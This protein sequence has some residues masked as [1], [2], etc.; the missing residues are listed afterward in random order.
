MVITRYKVDG[1][2]LKIALVAD[3]HGLPTK[4]LYKA[5]EGEK[6]DVILAP[7]NIIL[8][9][10]NDVNLSYIYTINETYTDRI[11][12]ADIVFVFMDKNSVPN[13]V[14]DNCD[15]VYGIGTKNCGS[16]NGNIY[17]HRFFADYYLQSIDLDEGYRALNDS[18][19]ESWGE[20]YVDMIAPV[21]N[22]DGKIMVITDDKMFISQ[23]CRHLT[24]GGAEY[25]A[26][27][28]DLDKYLNK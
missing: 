1:P 5:L 28:L 7:G 14:L 15:C 9:S 20:N 3:I 8:E 6:P 17:S 22:T 18:W 10:E 21:T 16:N 23:D 26:K 24:Q 11:R 12:Q 4:E 19:K 27:H 2:K 25:Y 13:Y